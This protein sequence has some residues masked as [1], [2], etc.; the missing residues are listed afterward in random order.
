MCN[1]NYSRNIGGAFWVYI[2]KIHGSVKKRGFAQPKSNERVESNRF[3]KMVKRV[4][5]FVI[6]SEVAT[7]YEIAYGNGKRVK[8]KRHSDFLWGGI[9][10]KSKK[11][12]LLKENV[13]SLWNTL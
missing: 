3:F 2:E 9:L 4:F 5:S 6:F 7:S 10:C 8:G 11:S 12:K 1:R 13:L